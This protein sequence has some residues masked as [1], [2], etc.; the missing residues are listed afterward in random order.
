MHEGTETLV[1]ILSF[2]CTGGFIGTYIVICSEYLNPFN[3]VGL[4]IAEIWIGIALTVISFIF[5][6][7]FWNWT[8]IFI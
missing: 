4:I 2:L 8:E 3:S 7:M 6:S 1:G 5:F